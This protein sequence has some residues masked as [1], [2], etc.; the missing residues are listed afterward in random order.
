MKQKK[1]KFE[2]DIHITIGTL[3]SEF[4]Q[5]HDL[6]FAYWASVGSSL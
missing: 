4:V 1:K 5:T 3:S 2:I 6:D